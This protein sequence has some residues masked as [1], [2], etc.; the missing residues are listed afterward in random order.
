[1][2]SWWCGEGESGFDKTPVDQGGPVLDSAQAGTDAGN[3]V[4]G[5]GEDGVG[6][7]PAQQCPQA[8]DGVEIGSVCRESVDGQPV[9]AGEQVAHAG[10]DVGAPPVPHQD[11]PP[12]R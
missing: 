11:D 8:L 12:A 9:V 10:G 6:Q 2:S 1:M 5:V 7:P 3:E 4:V